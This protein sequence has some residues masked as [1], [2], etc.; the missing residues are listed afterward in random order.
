MPFLQFLIQ[1]FNQVNQREKE[2]AQ[3]N[4][5]MGPGDVPNGLRGF[6]TKLINQGAT[7]YSMRLLHE[8]KFQKK[9]KVPTLVRIINKGDNSFS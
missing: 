8:S 1:S 4:I 6:N 3:S 9:K 5:I 7:E 2:A